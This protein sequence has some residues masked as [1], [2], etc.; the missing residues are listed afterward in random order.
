M[1]FKIV[2]IITLVIATIIL[3][4]GVAVIIKKRKDGT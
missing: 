1:F 4:G 2:E 3:V